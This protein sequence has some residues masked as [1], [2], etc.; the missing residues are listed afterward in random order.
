MPRRKLLITT[1]LKIIF[2]FVLSTERAIQ[3]IIFK[4]LRNNANV[5]LANLYSNHVVCSSKQLKDLTLDFTF[6]VLDENTKCRQRFI[7]NSE[8]FAK[9][10]FVF[11]LN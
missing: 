2:L 10:G 8:S 5:W 9:N 3:V 1:L 11:Y 6:S 7:K 4:L